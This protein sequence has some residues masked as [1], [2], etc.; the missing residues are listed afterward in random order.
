MNTSPPNNE[1]AAEPVPA[2]TDDVIAKFRDGIRLALPEVEA[3][4]AGRATTMLASSTSDTAAKSDQ[5]IGD[6]RIV[7]R[8]DND[9]GGMGQV[10]EAIHEINK[11]RVALKVIKPG[12]MT[13]EMRRRFD[14]EAKLLAK[15]E[16]P[17]IARVFYAGIANAG[18]VPQPYFAMQF[19]EGKPLDK[20][21][22]SCDPPLKVRAKM[23]L[24]H[25]VCEAVSHAHGRGI[26]HRDLKP[27][28][29]LVT[30]EGKPIILD[31]GIARA[32]D[33]DAQIVSQHSQTGQLIGTVPYMAPEQIRGQVDELD[34]ATDVYA[35]G[36]IGYELLSD[37]PVK[38][39]QLPEAA[40]IICFDEPSQLSSVNKSL[41]GDIETIVQKALEKEKPRRFANAGQ[42][43]AQ[44]RRYLNY[45]PLTIRPPSTWYNVRKFAKRNRILVAGIAAVFVALLAGVIGTT[46]FAIRAEQNRSE[47]DTA[48]KRSESALE[49]VTRSLRSSDPAQ[50]GTQDTTIL[51]AMEAAIRELNSG[52][53]EHDPQLKAALSSTIAEILKN[54]GRPAAAVPLLLDALQIQE[55]TI[56]RD[57]KNMAIALNNLAS[58]Y[59]LLGRFADAEGLYRRALQIWQRLNGSENT[60]VATCL[61]NLAISQRRLGRVHEALQLYEQALEMRKRLYQAD[62][63]EIAQ[64]LSGLADAR[65]ALGHFE[66]AEHLNEQAL[67]VTLRLHPED[68]PNVALC[69]SNLAYVKGMCKRM[70]DA[71]PLLQRALEMR[72]RLFKGDHPDIAASL[73]NLASARRVLGR[74]NEAEPLYRA[75]LEMRQ[76]LY[77]HLDSGHPDLATSLN[78]MAFVLQDLNRGREAEVFLRDALAMRRRLFPAHHPA[79]VASLD[80]LASFELARGNLREAEALSREALSLARANPPLSDPAPRPTHTQS[81]T[82]ARTHASCLDALGRHDEAAAVRKE[83]GLPES[84][85]RA[86]SAPMTS[87]TPQPATAPVL[88]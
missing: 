35:L 2:K 84:T 69:L 18:S 76:R 80:N 28:N 56:S 25:E 78:S 88:R 45:E 74:P 54:N 83:F 44:V 82:C 3:R 64:S 67:A 86:S 24:F 34:W 5:V 52:V 85:T 71:E 11:Q 65:A 46:T 10:Y 53:I 59:E 33:A 14:Y 13:D 31:F 63:D 49:F 81:T 27:D 58:V 50:G 41:R 6:Y 4:D 72:Q 1:R 21:V 73:N 17:G 42:L 70:S 32:I 48:K 26:V 7:R 47:A 22:Q 66:D 79:V 75:A 55:R 60:D 16:H 29:I 12:R 62:H 15:L 57:H 8:I 36:V 30:S 37:R 77:R 23:K 51:H 38:G 68:H 20:Y 43:A 61:H 9:T 87:A 40:R 39:Q 19:I